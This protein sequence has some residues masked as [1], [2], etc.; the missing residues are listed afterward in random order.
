MKKIFIL[1]ISLLS[2]Y[3]HAFADS[4][5]DID[6]SISQSL[7]LSLQYNK[8]ADCFHW[9][10][11]VSESTLN[12]FQIP[13]YRDAWISR[14]GLS[15]KDQSYFERFRTIR[16]KYQNGETLDFLL[17]NSFF[18]PDPALVKDPMMNAFY[19][20][21][22]IFNVLLKLSNVLTMEE[23]KFLDDFYN[24]FKER[25]EQVVD[26]GQQDRKAT[27]DLLN[28]HLLSSASSQHLFMMKTF[29]NASPEKIRSMLLFSAPKGHLSGS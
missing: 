7:L 1:F 26:L 3:N 27:L 28:S 12:F 21:T 22:D 18:A 23:L 15:D 17:A 25:I 2:L 9:L 16:K 6:F 8:L 10:D 20:E 24:H 14:W 13:E 29:Y 5:N 19:S 11:Q 4:K